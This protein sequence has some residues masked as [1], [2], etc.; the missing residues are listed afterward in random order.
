MRILSRG[1]ASRSSISVTKAA[2]GWIE[3]E[4]WANLTLWGELSS[5]DSDPDRLN[6]PFFLHRSTP[7]WGRPTVRDCTVHTV[8]SMCM[9]VTGHN[10]NDVMRDSKIIISD[11]T[12]DRRGTCTI[13]PPTITLYDSTQS[14]SYL[15]SASTSDTFGVHML[16]MTCTCTSMYVHV[17]YI[18]YNI[19]PSPSS[20]LPSPPLP[21]P[22]T[23]KKAIKHTHSFPSIKTRFLSAKKIRA[24]DSHVWNSLI[25]HV[26]A[27]SISS[28]LPY[29]SSRFPISLICPMSVCDA[30]Y[31]ITVHHLN[32]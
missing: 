29:Q 2:D 27:I 12:I 14:T 5:F 23:P 25:T 3:V 28:S 26:V 11:K 24:N 32:V 16:Y 30:H 6:H 13:P 1:Q 4:R 9:C 18:L 10:D 20:I 22:S 8:H 15:Q 7:C 31:Y 17:L 19:N 21:R